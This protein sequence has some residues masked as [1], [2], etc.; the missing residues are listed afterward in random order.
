MPRMYH[1]LLSPPSNVT[2]VPDVPD[3]VAVF[4]DAGWVVEPDPAPTPPGIVPEPVRYEPVAEPVKAKR[5]AKSST[6]DQPG[7]DIDN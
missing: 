7:E 2:D 6:A 5:A 3:C 4:E 1:P